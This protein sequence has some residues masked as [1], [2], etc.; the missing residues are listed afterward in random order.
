[1]I[2][3]HVIVSGRV[4]GVFFRD[5]C[6]QAARRHRVSGWVT[7]RDDGSVEAVFE[8][9]DGAV[10]EMVDWMRHGPPRAQVTG[11]DVT[12]ERP[13]GLPDFSVR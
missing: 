13:E 10:R 12:D 9:D 6:E 3:K 7:N 2:R 1:V 11:V 8:G 4:Q 5:G